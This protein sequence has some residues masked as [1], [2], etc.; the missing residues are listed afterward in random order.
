MRE[1]CMMGIQRSWPDAGHSDIDPRE[2]KKLGKLAFGI[3]TLVPGVYRLCVNGT[4][5]TDSARYCYS[6]WLRHLVK[7][8]ENGFR[9]FPRR[10]AELGPGDTLGVGLAALLSGVER[11]YAFDVV[12]HATFER[13]VR[14]FDQLVDLF[15]NKEDI[16][17]EDE[18]P[19]VRPCLG[20]YKFPGQVL[21]DEWLAQ[22]LSE[23]R[24]NKIR[25]SL[26]DV[27]RGDSLIR[28]HAPWY[29]SDHREESLDMIVS[30]AVLQA[31]DDLPKVYQAMR[32]WLKPNGLVSHEIDF[33]CQRTS[34]QWNGHWTYSDFVWKLMTGNR[35]YF[36]NREPHSTHVR[37]LQEN[38]F[39]IVFD[40]RITSK[41]TISRD[42]LAKRFRSLSDD[43]ITTS[44]AFIQGIK[45]H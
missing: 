22:S 17:G 16:P 28:Y 35:P 29:E 15:T 37:L 23:T 24:I 2:M 36:L 30:Q 5:G 31:V 43:D 41:S 21:T 6:V 13:N 18:F 38:G 11:Y 27:D 45:E 34:E 3:A 33:K 7:A 14:I 10:V 8:Y 39:R 44:G 20:E 32:S 25:Q 26:V 12:R 1:M 19:M 42:R 40:E 4:G 9:T